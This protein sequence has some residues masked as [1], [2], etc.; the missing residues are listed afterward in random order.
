MTTSDRSGISTT[1]LSLASVNASMSVGD[2]GLEGETTLESSRNTLFLTHSVVVVAAIVVGWAVVV[3][4]GVVV[5]ARI[6]TNIKLY[7]YDQQNCRQ[8]CKET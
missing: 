5:L 2:N 3:G 6:K 1:L 7:N 4:N 8:F